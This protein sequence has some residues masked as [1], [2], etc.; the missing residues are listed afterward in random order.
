LSKAC[1]LSIHLGLALSLYLVA[2]PISLSGG[3]LQLPLVAISIF[4]SDGTLQLPLVAL[5][6]S[7]VWQAEAQILEAIGVD[8]IDESEVL[9]PK[10]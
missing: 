5:S 8:Y 6:H 4:L 9:H 10:P 3:T 1:T 7:L 2:L